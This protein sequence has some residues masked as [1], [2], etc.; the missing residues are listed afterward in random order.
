MTE[1]EWLTCTDPT[2][3]LDFLRGKVT[4]RKLRLFGVA[5]C[6]EIWDWLNDSRKAVEIAEQYADSQFSLT[7]E[8]TRA[9]YEAGTSYLLL[10]TDPFQWAASYCKWSP[11]T[12]SRR[13]D[14]ANEQEGQ[15][16]LLRCIFG[17]PFR[18]IT[19]KPSLLTTTIVQLAETIYNERTF[20]R[21]P[22]LADALEESGA[23]D[24]ALLGHCRGPGPHARGCHV[25]DVILGKS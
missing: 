10:L 21:M 22:I 5:C 23:T 13:N 25:L 6:R 14:Q 3:M 20:D 7:K 24:S 9:F 17:N 11:S 8:A 1:H 12:I 19:I 2:Q 16:A 4:D 15:L 18:P